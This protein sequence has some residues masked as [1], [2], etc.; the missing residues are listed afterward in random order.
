MK[1]CHITS[2]HDPEDVRIFLK[3]CVSLVEQGY[4]VS[5]VQVGDSYNK[6]GVNI[7]GIGSP[8]KS[9]FKRFFSDTKRAYRKALEV[10]AD[11]YHFHDPELMPYGVKLKKKGKKVIFDC[12]ENT[13]DAILEKPY[14]PK[15]LR[16]MVRYFYKAME[17][18]AC[19]QFD[20]VVTVTP[21]QT[22]YFENMGVS[23]VEVRN[24][25]ILPEQFS[26]PT[27]S[28]KAIAFAG[29]ISK[30]WNHHIVIE[31]LK[32]IP[33]CRYILVGQDNSYRKSLEDLPAWNQVDYKGKKSH[34]EVMKILSECRIGVALLSPGNN[35]AWKTGTLG[36]T[37]IFEEMIAGLPIICT[38][39]TL[40]KEFV[41]E[42]QCGICVN[43]ED[44][45]SVESVIIQLLSNPEL[46]RS[47]GINGQRAIKEK[48]NWNI[49]KE[50]LFELYRRI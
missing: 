14:I 35:T 31:A 26:V 34:E 5:L 33:G 15:P 12:H 32:N 17:K 27:Y 40:W 42:Y 16:R 43:P 46:C 4:D 8:A 50:K 6:L 38:D 19:R 10:N 36:N 9:R 39:F 47:M 18:N 20:S 25:P 45:Q 37:K 7:I 23:V 30:Q 48:F 22:E 2:V 28:N 44:V 29:G 13:A 21:T 11:I 3:E 1:V 49:E 24:S 41:E